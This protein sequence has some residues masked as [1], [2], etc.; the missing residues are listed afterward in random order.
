MADLSFETNYWSDCCNTFDEEQ[1]HFVYSKYMGIQSSQFCFNAQGKK[2]VDIGGGPTSMLLKCVNLKEGCVVDPLHYPAW[3]YS[4]YETKGIRWQI[5]RGED[6][7]ETGFDECWI[8]NCLQHVD[9]PATII[10]NALQAAP[11]LRLFEWVDI[12]PYAGHPH[13][14]TQD[15]L[16]L[17]IGQ[18]GHVVELSESG[19][20]GRAYHNVYC[21]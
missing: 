18:F 10:R 7:V 15:K 6:F 1:K 5:E 20:Y 4:R 8:Y 13:E 14:L 17:W 12:P 11:I 3:T 21:R 2:I 16:D 19:C 9:C